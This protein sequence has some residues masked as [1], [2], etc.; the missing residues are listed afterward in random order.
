[1]VIFFMKLQLNT[2]LQKRVYSKNDPEV[3]NQ[4]L[5]LDTSS[6]SIK[7]SGHTKIH[8]YRDTNFIL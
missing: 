6:S 8:S 2:T 3:N 1:M 7:E 4:E 5:D